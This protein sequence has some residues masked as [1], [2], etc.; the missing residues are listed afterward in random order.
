MPP[1]GKS[2]GDQAAKEL[3]D[4]HSQADPRRKSQ[5][6]DE[7]ED[8]GGAAKSSVRILTCTQPRD[9]ST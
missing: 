3:D 7:G 6:T 5:G 2:D 4:A 9:A 8:E 1:D